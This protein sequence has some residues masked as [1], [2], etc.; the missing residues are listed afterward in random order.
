MSPLD[1]AAGFVTV[2][3]TLDAEIAG[4]SAGLGVYIQ[5]VHMGADTHCE[6][7]LP[8]DPTDAAQTRRAEALFEQGSRA[9]FRAGAYFSRPYGMWADMVFNADAETTAATRKIKEIFDPGHVMNP[10]KLCF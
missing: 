3:K 2:M 7:I 1:R 4:A 10:G 6:F 9:L 8:Y 5:P